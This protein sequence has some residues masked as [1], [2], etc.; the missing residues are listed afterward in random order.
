MFDIGSKDSCKAK[1]SDPQL[2]F[3]SCQPRR[4]FLWGERP[5]PESP[6][7]AVSLLLFLLLCFLRLDSPC[8]SLPSS[9]LLR[10]SADPPS[11]IKPSSSLSRR[12]VEARAGYSLS[13]SLSHFT[14]I[15]FR[16]V[17]VLRQTLKSENSTERYD[18]RSELHEIDRG[19]DTLHRGAVCN[20]LQCIQ[21]AAVH[22][23]NHH[24]FLYCQ[25]RVVSGD[26]L[27]M[28]WYLV[29]LGT[30]DV[31]WLE[32]KHHESVLPRALG[33][34]PHSNRS[35]P[36]RVYKEHHYLTC[37]HPERLTFSKLFRLQKF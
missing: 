1:F 35:S 7:S 11:M 8:R 23:I 2:Q 5:L 31:V 36:R 22:S 30:L 14:A 27:F 26:H 29:G 3:S 34:A 12:A 4:P 9:S 28:I 20:M 19:R 33:H 10:C 6:R 21:Y 17:R 15:F 25:V 32:C 16:P 37:H 13:S 18:L 24:I